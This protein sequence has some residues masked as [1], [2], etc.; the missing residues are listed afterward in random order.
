MEP[1]ILVTLAAATLQN[2]RTVLQKRLVGRLSVTAST[3]ARFLYGLPLTWGGVWITLEITGRPLP[4]VSWR[5][6][7]YVT[8][9]GV[10]QVLG[11]ALFIHLIRAANF[12]VI[13]SYIKVETVVGALLSFILLGDRLSMLGVGGVLISLLGVMVLSAGKSAFTLRSLVTALGE[14]AALGGVAVGALYAVASTSIRGASLTLGEPQP[15]LAA[16]FGL[17]WVTLLQAVALT[18]WLAATAPLELRETFRAWRPAVWV[19][20][21][22]VTASGLWYLAFTLQVTAYVLALGQVELIFAYLAS[23]FLFKEHTHAGELAGM[24][25]T[26]AGILTV[27][28]AR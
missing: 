12:T 20:I 6:I 15:V 22:G 27:I 11:N 9:A 3:Y 17:A 7:A 10:A 21:S 5:F 26:V 2:F 1:W 14:R 16:M 28:A 13:T 24:A 19:G 18:G 25:V 4:D 23:R 8:V